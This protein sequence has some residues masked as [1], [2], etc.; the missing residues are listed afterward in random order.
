MSRLERQ[1]RRRRHGGSPLKRAFLM[2]AVLIVAGVALGVLAAVGFTAATASAPDV[3]ISA[4]VSD[5][6]NRSWT[7]LLFVEL[8]GPAL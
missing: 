2:G 4:V 7:R 5:G 3:H 8:P 6:H 1:R